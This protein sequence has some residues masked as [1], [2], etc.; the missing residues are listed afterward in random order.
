[1]ATKINANPISN[2]LVMT[3]PYSKTENSTPKTDSRLRSSAACEGL[4]YASET[5]WMPNAMIDANTMRKAIWPIIVGVITAT[6]GSVSVAAPTMHP[7]QPSVMNWN[8]VS[9]SAS[10][11]SVNLDTKTI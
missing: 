7:K 5:F 1:M 9:I 8:T 6:A 4:T 3:S 2:R 11:F 10:C